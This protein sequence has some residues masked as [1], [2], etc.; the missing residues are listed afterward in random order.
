[1]RNQPRTTVCT[2]L[3]W[4][5]RR[6]AQRDA[7]LL[8]LLQALKECKQCKEREEDAGVPMGWQKLIATQQPHTKPGVRL[9][10]PRTRHRPVIGLCRGKCGNIGNACPWVGSEFAW[11]ER[12]IQL[13]RVGVTGKWPR[14]CVEMRAAGWTE[15]GMHWHE[16]MNGWKD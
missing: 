7:V 4:Q 6:P 11:C 1:M 9:V 8:L 3:E 16:W 14:G 5:E 2:D 12:W 13:G 10:E 15:M